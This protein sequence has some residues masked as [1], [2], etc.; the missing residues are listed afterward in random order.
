MTTPYAK[1]RETPLWRALAAAVS[2]LQAT[3]EISVAT[4]SDYVI[5]Y[6]CMEL[7]ARG[8]VSMKTPLEG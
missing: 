5:G 3:G 1:Y 8:L 2:E 6:L 4:G 7:V